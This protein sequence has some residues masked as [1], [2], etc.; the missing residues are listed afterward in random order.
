MTHKTEMIVLGFLVWSS[1]LSP[2]SAFRGK[3][4]S[5]IKLRHGPSL[6]GKK[7]NSFSKCPEVNEDSVS[8]HVLKKNNRIKKNFFNNP[9][10]I[11]F[12]SLKI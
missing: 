2:S 6:W 1:W 4:K 8:V 7:K 10:T 9:H 5:C 3:R 12:T 11:K